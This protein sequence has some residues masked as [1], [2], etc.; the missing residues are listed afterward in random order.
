M[1]LSFFQEQATDCIS[2]N[3]LSD[4]VNEIIPPTFSRAFFFP[5]LSTLMFYLRRTGRDSEHLLTFV[6][7]LFF[8][9]HSISVTRDICNFESNL[10]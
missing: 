3:S 6:Y 10:K 4:L 5:N 9:N 8:F 7:K 1:L 2:C